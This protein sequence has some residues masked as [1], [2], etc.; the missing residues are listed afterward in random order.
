[1][2]DSQRYRNHSR[3]NFSLIL[4]SPQ[5]LRFERRQRPYSTPTEFLRRLWTRTPIPFLRISSTP[6]M[7]NRCYKHISKSQLKEK[8]NEDM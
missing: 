7:L 3:D 1:M 2:N 6:E 8:E 4:Q 5:P